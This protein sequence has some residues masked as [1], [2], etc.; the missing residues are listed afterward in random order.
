MSTIKMVQLPVNLQLRLNKNIEKPF[1]VSL[2]LAPGYLIGSNALYANTKANVYYSEMAQFT[3][4]QLMVH[5]NLQAAMI[6]SRFYNLTLGP[7][8]QYGLSNMARRSSGTS[9]HLFTL[10]IKSYLNLK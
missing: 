3:R 2:G 7:A 4:F 10:G 1:T 5:G 6:N 8:F 9:Q